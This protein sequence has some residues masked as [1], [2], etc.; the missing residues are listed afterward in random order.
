MKSPSGIIQMIIRVVGLIVLAM[1]I[2][3]WTT[4]SNPHLKSGHEA[5]GILL[6]L[7]LWT[8]AGLALRAKVSTPLVALAVLWGLIAPIL[9]FAQVNIDHG[10]SHPIQALHLLVG[11]GVIG[12]AEIL[13]GR[14]KQAGTAA[15][16][17]R[18]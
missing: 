6:V 1:G 10:N 8:L 9:G 12:L 16:P 13:G 4:D 3:L 7:A 14:I 17:P 5:L 11:L 15:L 18:R 2:V